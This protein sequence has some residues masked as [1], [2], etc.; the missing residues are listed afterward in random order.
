MS[1]KEKKI[2]NLY[3][4]KIIQEELGNI[5]KKIKNS[6]YTTAQPIANTE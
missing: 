1:G 5:L 2:D 4:R 3:V 6:L